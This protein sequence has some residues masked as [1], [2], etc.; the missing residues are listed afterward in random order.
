MSGAQPAPSSA[1]SF[2]QS[3]EGSSFGFSEMTSTASSSSFNSG[4]S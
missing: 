2:S 4:V 1:D 3:S